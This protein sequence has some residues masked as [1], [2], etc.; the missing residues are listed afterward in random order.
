MTFIA[1]RILDQGLAV[2][3]DSAN[4]IDICL[5]EPRSFNEATNDFSIG[6][7]TGIKAGFPAT[8]WPSGRR[9]TIPQITSGSIT[10]SGTARFV[11]ITNTDANELLA[12]GDLR[13]PMAVSAGNLFNLEP[14]EIVFPGV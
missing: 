11:A 8:H 5:A 9:V 7:K 10:K 14:F 6:N 3:E 2:L 12:A 1:D 13:N 4:R